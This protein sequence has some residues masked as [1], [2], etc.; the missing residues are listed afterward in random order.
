MAEILKVEIP[1][2]MK[3]TKFDSNTPPKV[4]V[5]CQDART[6]YQLRQFL[7]QGGERFLLFTAM[8]HAIP[9]G[10]LSQSY[11]KV[12]NT[13]FIEKDIL[14]RNKPDGSEVTDTEAGPKQEDELTQLLSKD[15][16]TDEDIFQESYVLTMTQQGMEEC[17]LSKEESSDNDDNSINASVFEPFP[18]V[19]ELSLRS[20]QVVD[21]FCIFSDG[22]P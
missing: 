17:H 18:E 3:V 4:L 13:Q 20:L 11:E 8:K 1:S 22:K 10:K 16:H 15:D 7:T 14:P 19:I 21:V 9:I 6:C 2:D 12:K 5:L